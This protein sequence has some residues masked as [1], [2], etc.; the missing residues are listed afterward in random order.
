MQ[1]SSRKA[2]RIGYIDS[3]YDDELGFVGG[4]LIVNRN[5]RPLEFHC[6]LPLH[7]KPAQKVL[8]GAT[9]NS[10]LLIE[11]IPNS[12]LAKAKSKPDVL[13]ANRLE[14]VSLFQSTEI[15]IGVLRGR[16]ARI[17]KDEE[18]E[19]NGLVIGEVEFSHIGELS[20]A[21]PLCWRG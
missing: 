10:Y 6:T 2:E 16:E 13:I 11:Q 18:A 14:L 9:L 12:L 19:A 7:P 21:F 15:P 1:A 17:E 4:L 3:K 20:F 8:Y 5:A